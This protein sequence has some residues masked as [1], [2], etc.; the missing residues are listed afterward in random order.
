[1]HHVKFDIA[2]CLKECIAQENI[3]DLGDDLFF[4]SPLTS[5]ETSPMSTPAV[6]ATELPAEN[7]GDDLFSLSPLTSAEPSPMSTPAVKATELPVE[8]S[9]ISQAIEL[10]STAQER[11]KR[12]RKTQGRKNCAKR[13]CIDKKEERDDPPIRTKA[14]EKYAANFVPVFTSTS[15]T[16]SNVASTS[17]VALNR[18]TNAREYLLKELRNMGFDILKWD[19]W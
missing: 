16:E 10:L 11:L 1:M 4:L 7:S 8:N 19:G 14:E 9:G 15:V 18:S 2:S 12:R 17:Y 3:E 13:H 5:A 6:K